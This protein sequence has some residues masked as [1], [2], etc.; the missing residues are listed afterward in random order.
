MIR[1]NLAVA[2]VLPWQLCPP[3]VNCRLAPEHKPLLICCWASC[4]KATGAAWL[5]ATASQEPKIRA[6]PSKYFTLVIIAAAI[7]NLVTESLSFGQYEPDNYLGQ[8]DN[9]QTDKGV[10]NRV[11]GAGDFLAGTTAGNIFEA[12]VDDHDDGYHADYD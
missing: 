2:S 4:A 10:K 5:K 1:L 12:A 9:D 7:V 11:F 8:C 6:K 3:S